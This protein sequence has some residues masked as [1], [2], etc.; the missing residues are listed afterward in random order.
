LFGQLYGGSS[1]CTNP[2]GSNIYGRFDKAYAA[3][4]LGQW[5]NASNAGLFAAVLPYARSVQ[6][7][8]PATAFGTIVNATGLDARGCYLALPAS[9]AIPATFNYQTTNASNQLVGKVNT[10][11][12]IPAGGSQSFV[13]GITPSAAF[14]ATNIPVVF[15]CA[16]TLPAPSQTGLNLNSSVSRSMRQAETVSGGAAVVAA[17]V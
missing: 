14:A 1:S 17:W 4:N 7:G 5:L 13:F 2:S 6:I 10:P 9:P 11:I 16:N 12:D 8:Q 3:G 15:D